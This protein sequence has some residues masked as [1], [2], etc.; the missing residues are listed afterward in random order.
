M[1]I[2]K[3]EWMHFGYLRFLFRGCPADTA[4]LLLNIARFLAVRVGIEKIASRLRPP[5]DS[6]SM[7][8][9]RWFLL[10]NAGRLWVLLHGTQSLL[11]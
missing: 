10:K 2:I 7:Q 4:Y 3:L 9:I 8:E 1:K 5:S 11:C 6:G